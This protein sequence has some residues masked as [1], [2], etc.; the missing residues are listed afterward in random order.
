MTFQSCFKIDEKNWAARNASIQTPW[1]SRSLAPGQHAD[2][3]N[4]MG[5][6]NI[7]TAEVAHPGHEAQ[8]L[9]NRAGFERRP[10]RPVYL[11]LRTLDRIRPI[12]WPGGRLYLGQPTPRPDPSHEAGEPSLGWAA[13]SRRAAETRVR[14][15]P[16]DGVPLFFEA[17]LEDHLKAGSRSCAIS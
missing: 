12:S 17:D 15:L 1:T 11:R 14:R 7:T 10:E 3:I 4:V 6:V 9:A 16:I 5:I 2:L 8:M 13:H